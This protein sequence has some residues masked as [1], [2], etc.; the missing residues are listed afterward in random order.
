MRPVREREGAMNVHEYDCA[1]PT[2]A[3][4]HVLTE[5]TG[6]K[7]KCSSCGRRLRLVRVKRRMDEETKAML[8]ARARERQEVPE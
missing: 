2:C 1:E 3:R 7:P 4:Y 5:R 8:R 6:E